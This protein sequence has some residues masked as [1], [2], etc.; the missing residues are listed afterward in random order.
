LATTTREESPE[1]RSGWGEVETIEVAR[2]ERR[3]VGLTAEEIGLSLDE[4]KQVL[5]AVQRLVLQTQM[6]EYTYCARVCPACLKMRRQ[7]DLSHANHTDTVRDSDGE[8]TADQHLSLFEHE[9]VRRPVVFI[10]D[11]FTP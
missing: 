1:S 6:E 10:A 11:G 3:V 8:G 5:A 2:F 9:G 7:R 4:A